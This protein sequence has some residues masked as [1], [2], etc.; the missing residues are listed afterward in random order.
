[1]TRGSCV[2]QSMSLT[3]SSSPVQL[4][5]HCME[6][7]HQTETNVFGEAHNAIGKQANHAKELAIAEYLCLNA[8]IS[9]KIAKHTVL[10]MLLCQ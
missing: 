1:M 9:S 6:D 5:F 8:A 3:S 2:N 4:L 10:T 7:G